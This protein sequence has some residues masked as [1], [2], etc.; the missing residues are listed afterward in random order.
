MKK[1]ARRCDTPFFFA[2]A[3][4]R[5]FNRWL[6]KK[7]TESAFSFYLGPCFTMAID[8]YFIYLSKKPITISGYLP[9]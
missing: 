3:A 7:K 2:R 5:N 1:P 9:K 6:N 4:S 8:P